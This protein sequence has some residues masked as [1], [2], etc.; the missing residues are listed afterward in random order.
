MKKTC[1]KNLL[2]SLSVAFLAAT[3]TLF[4][5]WAV[6]K[7]DP[8][9][10][11]LNDLLFQ[12]TPFVYWMKYVSD[13]LVVAAILVMITYIFPKRKKLFFK[14]VSLV[15]VMYFFRALLLILTPIGHPE[16]DF[17]YYGDRSFLIN[18]FFPSGH[19]AFI[20]LCYMFVNKKEEPLIKN[21][22]LVFLVF[23]IVSLILSR[24]HYSID[25]AGGLLLGYFVFNVF[26]KKGW[27]PER[28]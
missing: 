11:Y 12:L 26:E 20:F 13:L 10:V 24:S 17:L 3:A 6:P 7:I 9:P 14:F 23:E 18:S 4:S 8:K 21:L 27:L 15:S 16:R 22:L 2:L 28:K 25:I 19:T 1:K 5:F